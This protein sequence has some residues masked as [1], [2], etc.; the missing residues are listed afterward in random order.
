MILQIEIDTFTKSGHKVHEFIENLKNKEGVRY[1]N[2]VEEVLTKEEFKELNLR[3]IKKIK[4]K[5]VQSNFNQTGRD[6]SNDNRCVR[7]NS[8]VAG[9]KT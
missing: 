2:H 9:I 7:R 8:R 6:F 5:H 1:I 3:T 4:E